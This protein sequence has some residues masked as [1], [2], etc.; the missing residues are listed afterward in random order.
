MEID[1]QQDQEGEEE[2]FMKKILQEWRHLDERFI[3][4][5]QKQIYK[6]MFQRYKEK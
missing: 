1:P 6:D 2:Q 4:D 3:P 5:D